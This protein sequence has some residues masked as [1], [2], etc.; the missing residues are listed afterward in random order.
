VRY[1][2]F[3]VAR[4]PFDDLR[5]R[6]ALSQAVDRDRLVRSVVPGGELASLRVAPRGVGAEIA[7]PLA[8][9]TAAQRLTR[10]RATLRASRTRERL[11]RPLQLRV[12]SGNGEEL[13]LAVAAMW[14]A[15][16]LPTVTLRSEIRSLIADLRRGDFDVALTGAQEP[17]ALESYLER[18][19]AGSSYNTGRY[20]GREFESLL[21]KALRVADPVAREAAMSVAEKR[22]AADHPVV[23]LIQEVA[24][25]LV[26]VRVDGW[27]DNPEDLHLSRHLGLRATGANDSGV[28]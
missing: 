24:R 22:L 26:D 7:T 13:C 25:N 27:V 14:T 3:N 18:F 28:K 8:E 11:G 1:L 17:P 6:E 23:P 16:G 9:G 5:V 19:R 21:E 12:P 2:R 15:A 20:A 10:A 4:A